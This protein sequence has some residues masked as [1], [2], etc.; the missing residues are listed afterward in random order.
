MS[1]IITPGGLPQPPTI[2]FL[3]LFSFIITEEQT[4]HAEYPGFTEA[5]QETFPNLNS[6]FQQEKQNTSNPDYQEKSENSGVNENENTNDK[7]Q[8]HIHGRNNN[9]QENIAKLTAKETDNVKMLTENNTLEGYGSVPKQVDSGLYSI[10][11]DEKD[12]ENSEKNVETKDEKE[13]SENLDNSNNSEEDSSRSTCPICDMDFASK[14]KVNSHIK[15]SHLAEPVCYICGKRYKDLI[16]L[17]IHIRKLHKQELY[18]I[19][20][21]QVNTSQVMIYFILPLSIFI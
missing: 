20:P 5:F 14:Q 4:D 17:K 19:K 6:V 1:A 8:E 9:S 3:L 12:P 15:K 16:I 2:K 11:A 18:E 7:Y 21:H 10:L 13:E